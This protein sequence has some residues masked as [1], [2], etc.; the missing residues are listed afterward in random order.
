MSL[1][2]SFAKIF[3]LILI[4]T[5]SILSVV[6]VTTRNA[7]EIQ[8][9]LSPEEVENES[10]ELFEKE[11][12]NEKINYYDYNFSSIYLL[13]AKFTQSCK[14]SAFNQN[15][16]YSGSNFSNIFIPPPEHTI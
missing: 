14:T 1:F 3:L 15:F 11:L 12:E 8:E 9:V 2:H 10:K 13:E 7:D 4:L 5:H 6:V 16:I